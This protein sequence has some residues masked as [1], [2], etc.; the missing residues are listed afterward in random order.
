MQ[1]LSPR[2]GAPPSR[3]GDASHAHR[4]APYACARRARPAP[5]AGPDPDHQTPSHPAPRRRAGR[6]VRLVG[7][8]PTDVSERQC[9]HGI[10]DLAG[11]HRSPRA[12][13]PRDHV[14]RAW[15]PVQG[16]GRRTRAGDPVLPLQRQRRPTHRH[17]LGPGRQGPGASHV[18]RLQW[19]GLAAGRPRAAGTGRQGSGLHGLVPSAARP[20]RR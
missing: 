20:L 15:R 3:H 8:S 7:H 11:Q 2:P 16:R 10:L 13:R 5:R 19:V 14:R 1:G 9:D 18:P 17:P 6:C 12:G 4:K